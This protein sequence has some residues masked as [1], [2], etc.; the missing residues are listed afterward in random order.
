MAQLRYVW[1]VGCVSG[2]TCAPFLCAELVPENYTK[3]SLRGSPRLRKAHGGEWP[4]VFS[5][6]G[7]V[8]GE[9]VLHNCPVCGNGCLVVQHVSTLTHEAHPLAS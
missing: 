1:D 6:G 8:E 7:L 3:S 2:G 4:E 9:A 5:G